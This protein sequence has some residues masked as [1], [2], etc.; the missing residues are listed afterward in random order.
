MEETGVPRENHWPAENHWQTLSHNVNQRNVV[1]N[2][3][4]WRWKGWDYYGESDPHMSALLHNELV[5]QSTFDSDDV[6][7]TLLYDI[8]NNIY[9]LHFPCKTTYFSYDII[10]FLF[11]SLF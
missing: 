2:I 7:T 3:E 8:N 6:P 5:G 10:Q 9:C 11:M 4:L 1:K